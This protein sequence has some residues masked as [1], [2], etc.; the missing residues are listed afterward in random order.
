MKRMNYKDRKTFYLFFAGCSLFA[1]ISFFVLSFF[2]DNK[3]AY[4]NGYYNISQSGALV[5]YGLIALVICIV[6]FLFFW[7]MQRTEKNSLKY[8]SVIE[9]KLKYSQEENGSL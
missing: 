1:S 7:F 8:K 2:S 3:E 5:F 9:L 6:L 4:L